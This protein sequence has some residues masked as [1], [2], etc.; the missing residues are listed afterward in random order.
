MFICLQLARDPW[1]VQFSG[2]RIPERGTSNHAASQQTPGRLDESRLPRQADSKSTLRHS[3]DSK[4][5]CVRIVKQGLPLLH[6]LALPQQAMLIEVTN[7]A[8]Q[9]SLRRFRC[10]QNTFI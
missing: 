5:L 3:P 7:R 4:P 9:H 6:L 2:T 8:H 10:A 1:I